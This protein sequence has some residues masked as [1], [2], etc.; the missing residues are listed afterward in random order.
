MKS[1]SIGI[2]GA[3]SYTGLELVKLLGVH[4]LC[5]LAFVSSKSY[6]GRPFSDVFARAGT[7][8]DRVLI[9]PQEAV[10]HSVEC[11]FSCLPHAVSADLLLPFYKKGVRIIDLSADFRIRD[12]GVYCRWYKH[13]HPAPQLLEQAVFGLPEVYREHIRSA[14]IVANPGC[15][16]TSVLLPLIPLLK[17]VDTEVNA[18]IADSKSG[19][20]GAGRALKLTSHF[21]EANENVKPYSIGRS[22]RHICEIEQELSLA[23]GSEVSIVFSPHL[24]PMTRGI[25]S[26]IYFQTNRSPGECLSIARQA[27]Q[28]E[29]FVR[30]RERGE[31]PATADV[32]G[33]NYCDLTFSDGNDATVIAV[34]A[35]DNL[36]KG[37]AGQAVHNMNIMFDF[38]ET[39]GL[40]R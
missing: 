10:S 29:P 30:V 31:L 25:L 14:Q 15:Y 6:A 17:D 23:S 7:V 3:T 24:M 18:I 12:A 8:E 33:T 16:P 32:A 5:E 22:H 39:A 37:A 38:K 28:R 21:V 9:S 1:I 2:L 26:T 36:V 27:Y 20:S 35:I 4:P 34:S 19:V 13:E 11:L 40:P